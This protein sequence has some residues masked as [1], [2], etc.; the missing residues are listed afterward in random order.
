[1]HIYDLHKRGKEDPEWVFCVKFTNDKKEEWA[2]YLNIRQNN[3]PDLNQLKE[4][5]EKFLVDLN[6]ERIK[7]EINEDTGEE[8]IDIIKPAGSWRIKA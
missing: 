6:K 1:M 2:P 7:L 8:T 5:A 4:E 3:Q